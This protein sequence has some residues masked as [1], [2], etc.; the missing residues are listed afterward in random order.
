M[1]CIDPRDLLPYLIGGVLFIF[2][3]LGALYKSY[4]CYDR[5]RQAEIS[6]LASQDRARQAEIAS[7]VS[8]IQKISDENT[9]HN[10]KIDTLVKEMDTLVKEMDSLKTDRQSTK[11][12]ST[13]DWRQ[14]REHARQQDIKLEALTE[15]LKSTYLSIVY[16]IYRSLLY[17]GVAS[18]AFWHSATLFPPEFPL[19]VSQ[20]TFLNEKLDTTARGADIAHKARLVYEEN[21]N[22]NGQSKQYTTRGL[23]L[24]YPPLSHVVAGGIPGNGPAVVND[25]NVVDAELL[26]ALEKNWNH[27]VQGR[28]RAAHEANAAELSQFLSTIQRFKT[29]AGSYWIPDFQLLARL[30]RILFGF[31]FG[32]ITNVMPQDQEQTLTNSGSLD[33]IVGEDEE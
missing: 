29:A 30:Y 11:L 22:P 28:D 17:K 2:S 8:R 18:F 20:L 4:S 25:R 13:E 1:A 23:L 15:A 19:N 26:K 10:R 14:Q 21:R 32:D 16:P 7:L 12:Q 33:T 9:K 31:E 27:V 3:A 6:S 24:K 5:A